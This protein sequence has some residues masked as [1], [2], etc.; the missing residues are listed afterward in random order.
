MKEFM[1]IL[2]IVITVLFGIPLAIT[3]LNN[4]NANCDTTHYEET[5]EYYNSM[6]DEWNEFTDAMI[7]YNVENGT[8]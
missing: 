5:T 1:V 3:G 2:G 8:W 4:A 7:K 6:A